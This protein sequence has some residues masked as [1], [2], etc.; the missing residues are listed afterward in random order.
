MA[1][2]PVLLDHRLRPLRKAALRREQSAPA[3]TGVRSVLPARSVA[4]MDAGRLA[5]VLRQAETPGGAEAEAYLD[6]AEA[7]EELDLHYLGVLQTRKRQVSQLPIS[8]EPATDSAEDRRDAELAGEFLSRRS[9]VDEIYDCLDS[10]G[11]GF[12]VSEIF[13]ETSERQWM[14]SRLEWRPPRWFAFDRE[15]GERVLLRGD[16][17]PEE[18]APWKFVVHRSKAKSGLTIRG[19]LARVAAWSW[20]FK[21]LSLK[22]WARF[23]EV[24]GQPMRLGRYHPNASDDDRAALERAVANIASDCAALMPEGMSIE[25]VADTTVRGRSA[26]FRD[27]IEYID[28]KL[29]IAV[30]GQTLTTQTGGTGSYALGQVHDLVRHDIEASDAAQLAETLERDLVR[31]IVAL[32][33]GPRQ[34][35]PRVVIERP[36]AHD[37]EKMA[38]VLSALVPLGLR[39]RVDDVRDRLGY[40]APGAGDEVLAAPAAAAMAAERPAV[41]LALALGRAGGGASADDPLAE[42]VEAIDG[43]EWQALAAPV[44]EPVLA[45]AKADPEGLLDGIASAYPEMDAEALTERL[46]RILFVADVY[47]RADAS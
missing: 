12:S 38:S 41:P 42:V 31:P 22:D 26:V 46:A 6:L 5:A 15:S 47:G 1:R 33:H 43:D 44:I 34:A 4:G 29:S 7:M 8:V 37:G 23:V 18:L 21:S 17:E 32:N 16:G 45:R 28:G 2:E 27:L 25:F 14:P 35:Y 13:W 19:G 30:L 11:K 10:I 3:V 9:I 39:V 40:A 24:Y 36:P 20:L